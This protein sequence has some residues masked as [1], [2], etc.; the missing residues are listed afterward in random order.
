MIRRTNK[1]AAKKCGRWKEVLDTY[2]R[3][4]MSCN[5]CRASTVQTKSRLLTEM[6]RQP[7]LSWSCNK[8]NTQSEYRKQFL[9]FC[10]QHFVC[11]LY[12]RRFSLAKFEILTADPFI[13]GSEVVSLGEQLPTFRRFLLPSSSKVKQSPLFLG[14]LDPEDEGTTV[15]RNVALLYPT[16]KL[17]S[18]VDLNV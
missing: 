12:V 13:L 10:S 8:H 11:S 6:W 5:Y 7:S 18:S 15:F 1:V 14:L 16:T 17:H 3:K 9:P 2:L 4:L